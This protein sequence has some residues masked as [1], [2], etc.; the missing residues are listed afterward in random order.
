MCNAIWVKLDNQRILDDIKLLEIGCKIL[1]LADFRGIQF[2]FY[3]EIKIS[4]Y[5][6]DNSKMS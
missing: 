5:K 2:T 1:L 4:L 6:T 3:M